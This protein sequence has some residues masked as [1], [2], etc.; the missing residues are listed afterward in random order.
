MAKTETSHAGGFAISLAPGHRSVE[1]AVLNAGQN[2]AAGTVLGRIMGGTAASAVKASGANTGGGTCTVDVTTPVRVGAQLGVYTVRCIAVAS[3]SGT[4]EVKDPQGRSLGQ[5]VVGTAFDDQIKFAL[6]DVGT[7]FAVG[8]GFDIT[9]SA[10]TGDYTILAPAGTDG[11]QVA[12]GIL[13][14]GVDAVADKACVVV[15]RDAEVNLNELTWPAGISA[16]NKA[17]ATS[18]LALAGIT[19]R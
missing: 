2:L 10:I 8:D 11:S 19:L 1:N 9:V 18:Q 5:A 13:W 12:A 14:D 7:D 15:V 16:T 17:I 3:N 6:A 4:F